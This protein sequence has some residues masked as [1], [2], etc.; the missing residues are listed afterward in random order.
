MSYI[1]RAYYS[2]ILPKLIGTY[3]CELIPAVETICRSGCDCIVDI[4]AA[5]GY[6]A[7]GMALRNPAATIV[8]FELNPSGRHS[9]RR[10]AAK[11]G[12]STRITI[13]GECRVENLRASLAEAQ[14]PAVICDCEGTED[15]L[16]R[17]DQ[18]EPLRRSLILV[19]THDGLKTAGGVLEGITHRL[20]ERFAPTH[21]IEVIAS[22]QRSRDDLPRNCTALSDEEA[23]EAMNEG[24]PWAQWL[25][26]K[27]R[28]D[29]ADR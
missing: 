15:A 4:G 23:A 6:Y 2:E 13:L 8:A 9:L 5:E 12:V 18:I 29:A 19:E 21:E 16:L 28:A 17:P 10:L 25:F 24:R 1:P 7:V 22:R 3:E 11:N 14:A 20:R 26:L 27:P